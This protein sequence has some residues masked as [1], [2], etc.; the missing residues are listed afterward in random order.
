VVTTAKRQANKK[1]LT[2]KGRV[3]A[4]ITRI[5][6]RLYQSSRGLVG[7]T[8]FQVAEKG[9]GFPI[10]PMKILLLTTIGR[11]SG[12]ERTA[13]LPYFEYEGRTFIVASFAGGPKN[14]AWYHNLK[15]TPSVGV[16]QGLKKYDASAQVLDADE[17]EHFW[18][19]LVDDWPRYGVYQE[20]TERTIPLVELSRA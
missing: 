13:P 9:Y 4:W 14:P 12:L 11:K 15:A 20:G 6:R 16:H 3:L 10:R 17:R 2:P 19:L 8:V 18:Q 7:G 5:H 1:Y